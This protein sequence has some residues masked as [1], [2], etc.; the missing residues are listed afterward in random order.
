MHHEVWLEIRPCMEPSNVREINPA[1]LP[2]FPA[3]SE[4]LKIA[5]NAG[6]KARLKNSGNLWDYSR[7]LNAGEVADISEIFDNCEVKEDDKSTSRTINVTY[8]GACYSLTLFS[9]KT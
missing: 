6:E 9:Y 7:R 1:M 4:G 3:L 5:E 8:N 2:R